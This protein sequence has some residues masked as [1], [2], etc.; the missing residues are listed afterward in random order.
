[1]VRRRVIRPIRPRRLGRHDGLAYA[2]FTPR[3]P[4]RRGV[5]IVHGAGSCKE[6]HYEF[7]RA[8][9]PLGIAALA[10]D[11]RGHGESDGPLDARAVEDVVAMAELLREALGD[12]AAPIGLRGSSMGGFLALLAAAPAEAAAVV[13]ICPASASLLAAGLRS[14]RLQL[15]A[16]P[17][18]VLSLLEVV[19]LEQTVKDLRAPLLLMHAEGDE[20][21]PVEHSR[22]LAAQMTGEDGRLVVVPGG[23][24]RS[25]Q[26]D[27]ELQAVSLR[28]LDRHL[29][30]SAGS[31]AGA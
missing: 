11:S 30:G 10:F 6:S 15:D 26:H 21:V 22:A 24:H 3:S 27:D 1:V 2:L 12:A 4:A 9:L 20:Q 8:L 5:V 13:A 23:H 17:A 18:A 25:I 28:F 19:D 16:E 14:G 29:R 31:R 7:A